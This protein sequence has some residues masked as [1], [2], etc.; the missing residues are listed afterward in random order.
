MRA[1]RPGRSLFVRRFG[2]RTSLAGR[3]L[4]GGI[5]FTALVIAGVSGFLL[6]S[7]SQQTNAGALS[8]A[9]NRAGVAGELISRVIQPQAQYAATAVASLVVA[10]AGAEREQPDRAGRGRVHRQADRRTSR[11]SGWSSSNSH[12]TVLYTSEC[13]SARVGGRHRPIRRP[14][15]CEQGAM[16]HVTAALASVRDALK[17]E[18]TAACQQPSATIAASPALASAVPLGRRGRRDC[19]PAGCPRSTWPCRC[20][21]LRRAPTHRSGWWCTARSCRRSSPGTARSSATR[22]CSSAPAPGASLIRFT[23]SADTPTPSAHRRP[24]RSSSRIHAA[25]VTSPRMP[26]TRLQGSARWPGASSRSRHPAGPPSPATSASR[27]RCRSSPPGTAQDEGTIAQ[28]AFTALVVVCL[29]VLLFVDRFVRRPVVAAG[30][31]R[32]ADRRRRLHDRHSG[33]LARRART[34][35]RRRQ[36]HA[37][38]DRRLHRAHRR[39]G[40]TAAGGVPRADDDHRRHRAAPGRGA[41]R[42]RRDRRR[43]RERDR[44]HATGI[45]VPA[46]AQPR[47]RDARHGRRDAGGRADRRTRGPPRLGRPRRPSPCRCSSRRRSP[48]SWS[49]R[50]I[51]RSPTATN[52]R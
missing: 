40:R 12:G 39:I 23:G 10:P 30:A 31:R 27:C 29:L 36:P 18:T 24:S 7:R 15:A 44:V 46:H 6:V 49:S 13:D 33:H 38:A 41:R 8:N 25:S 20:S 47:A 1:R 2:L 22:R 4:A 28:I 5:V 34:A 52:A 3:L 17:V 51:A 35:R 45:G 32:R 50:R 48:A 11:G 42:R 37:R 9:D 26:S 19:S 43:V 21:T 16:P 14:V